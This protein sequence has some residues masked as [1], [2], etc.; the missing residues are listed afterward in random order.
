[1]PLSNKDTNK[2]YVYNSN[3]YIYIYIY[4]I[5]TIE[6]SGKPILGIETEYKNQ[7]YS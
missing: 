1:M 7:K 2:L 6:K 3:I 4:M 5:D